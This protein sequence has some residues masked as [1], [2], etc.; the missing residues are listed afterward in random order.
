PSRS[1]IPQHSHFKALVTPSPLGLP[2]YSASGFDLLSI[3]ARV[4]TRPN[5]KIVLGPVDMTCSF[6]VTDSRRFDNPIVYASPSFC[7]LTGY[8]EQEVLGNNC[9]FLQAP[10]ANVHKDQPRKYTSTEAVNHLR[11]SLSANK[12]CQTS[13]IN[14]R[15]D[16]SA[17]INLVTVIPIPGGVLNTPQEVDEYVYHVGFQVDLTE[18]PN[19]I[20]N[21]LRDGSYAVNYS[22]QSIVTQQ[23]NPPP[24]LASRDWRSNASAMP[25][26]SKELKA[27]L[28]DTTFVNSLPLQTQGTPLSTTDSDPFDGNKLLHLLLLQSSPDFV[29]VVSLKGAFLYVAPSVKRVLGWAPQD[30]LGK[31]VTDFCHPADIVPLMRELKESSTHSNSSGLQKV[32]DLLFR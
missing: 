15:K 31:S 28:T 21:K 2:V 20:L 1:P 26:T 13:L 19:V 32:V 17:F 10:H 5:P 14:Y 25:G 6:V 16:G 23:S 12:E 24:P 29:H 18:Q 4:A 3:L 8:S 11:S 9:R 30:L 22:A 7:T 27:L